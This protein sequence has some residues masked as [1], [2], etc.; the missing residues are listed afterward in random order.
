MSAVMAAPVAAIAPCAGTRR[1]K[2]VDAR[3]KR[4]HDGGDGNGP[5]LAGNAFSIADVA[6]IP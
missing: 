3:A 6:V 5:Y 1:A 2:D 4:A